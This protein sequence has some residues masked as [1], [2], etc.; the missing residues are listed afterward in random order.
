MQVKG[1]YKYAVLVN[2]CNEQNQNWYCA[3]TIIHKNWEVTAAHCVE[4]LIQVSIVAGDMQR[5]KKDTN[6]E[7]RAHRNI[8]HPMSN[9]FTLLV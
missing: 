5:K 2:M 6:P 7:K 9:L 8:L 3:G 1:D 4:K